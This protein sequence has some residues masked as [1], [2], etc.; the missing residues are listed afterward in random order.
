MEGWG[1]RIWVREGDVE[2]KVRSIW[3]GEGG[4]GVRK[5]EDLGRGWVE[6]GGKRVRE[7]LVERGGG[8]SGGYGGV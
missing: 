6:G 8:D 4:R 3:V 2:D 1:E 5:D 7:G